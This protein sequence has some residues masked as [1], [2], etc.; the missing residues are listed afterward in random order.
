M[1]EGEIVRRLVLAIKGHGGQYSHTALKLVWV[2][3]CK[4][5]VINFYCMD[6]FFSR[7][8]CRSILL[9]ELLSQLWN[10]S[11]CQLTFRNLSSPVGQAG[12]PVAAGYFRPSASSGSGTSGRR[13]TDHVSGRSDSGATAAERSILE[14]LLAGL[15]DGPTRGECGRTV[16]QVHNTVQVAYRDHKL[17][18]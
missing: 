10:R 5:C 18:I 7:F 15:E 14:V 4:K 12:R 13:W 2:V 3:L 1:V 11:N 6:M 17:I 16:V 8:S 9:G